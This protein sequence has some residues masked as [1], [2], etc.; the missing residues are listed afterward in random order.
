[1]LRLGH[2]SFTLRKMEG[3]DM[4]VSMSK[5]VLQ[6]ILNALQRDVEAGK[7]VRQEYIEVILAD[8]KEIEDKHDKLD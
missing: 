6:L 5:A 7:V 8:I 1:M 4:R 3:F 2:I